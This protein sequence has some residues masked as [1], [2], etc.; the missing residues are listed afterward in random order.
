MRGELSSLCVKVLITRP[1]T[2]CS[3][4]EVRMSECSICRKAKSAFVMNNKT[5][6]MRCDDLLFDLE[7]EC[8]EERVVI[9]LRTTPLSKPQEETAKKS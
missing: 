1:Q 9:P 6:C 7:I 5:V 3:P 8:E 4:S 2:C